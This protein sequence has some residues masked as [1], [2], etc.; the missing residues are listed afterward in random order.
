MLWEPKVSWWVLYSGLVKRER[1]PA[2]LGYEV[3]RAIGKFGRTSV[4]L[5][6]ERDSK[7]FRNPGTVLE[8]AVIGP[9][10]CFIESVLQFYFKRKN[11][12]LE[13]RF[14]SKP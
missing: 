8:R 5:E 9:Q 13:S 1:V 6:M 3:F 10:M 12:F 14:N 4:P 2:I 11:I 7:E